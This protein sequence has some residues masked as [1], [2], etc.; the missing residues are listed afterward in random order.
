[1]FSGQ[2]V[3]KVTE[4]VCV[5][6]DLDYISPLHPILPSAYVFVVKNREWQDGDPL[7]D[8]YGDPTVITSGAGA[9]AFYSEVVQLQP[10]D[11]GEYDL[12]LDE[13]ADGYYDAGY[14]LVV[15]EGFDYAFFVIS[16]VIFSDDF[17]SGGSS[18]WSAVVGLT[19]VT[20][21][22][23]NLQWPAATSTS[24]GVTTENIFGQVY[25][26]GC[27]DQGP[28][29]CE[30]LI[31]QVGFGEPSIDP[32]AS[33]EAFTWADAVVNTGNSHPDNEEW[34]AQITPG[35]VGGY[36][37]VYRFSGDGRWTWSYCDL[38]DSGNGFSTDQMGFLTVTP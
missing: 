8:H 38:D 30:G 23:C 28:A 36:A 34:Q 15:G 33:P 19:V 21:D 14:D 16:D 20:I 22:W 31:A 3:F 6:G 12:V 24:V 18:A 25:V 11:P 27:T 26:A 29:V 5:S 9:G 37:Y 17:E 32:M 13:D 7:V 1:M 35:T 2:S 4:S 10:L